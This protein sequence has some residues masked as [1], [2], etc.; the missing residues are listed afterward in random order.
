LGG[1]S[2]EQPGQARAREKSRGTPLNN[3]S[4]IEKTDKTNTD[5]RGQDGAAKPRGD[6][7][8]R[9]GWRSMG[10]DKAR[11]YRPGQ[12]DNDGVFREMVYGAARRDSRVLDAGAGAGDLFVYD[13]KSRA[14][15]VLG[16]DL[17]PR[18]ETNPQLHRGIQCDLEKIP[19][20]GESVDVIFSRYVFEHVQNPRAFLKEMRRLLRPGGLLLFLTPNKW[21]YVSLISRC[22]PHVFH[23]W[24]NRRRGRANQDTFPTV[25]RLNSA[26][27]IRREM[28]RAGFCE[29]KLIFRECCPN[30]LLFSPPAFVCGVVYERIVNSVSFLAG[31][32]VNILGCFEKGKSRF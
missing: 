1:I 28:R 26:G 9:G 32:R 5:W 3:Y 23:R 29:R 11:W 17:D 25:Y 27:S 6:G 24:V 7:Q 12:F 16:A 21:H 30:Y 13:L 22:T 20:P 14:R 18:V 10:F 8:G 19:L 15:E 31:L 2:R 4:G